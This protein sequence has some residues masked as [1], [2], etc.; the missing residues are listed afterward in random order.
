MVGCL[1]AGAPTVPTPCS[2]R[3]ASVIRFKPPT[4]S[5]GQTVDRTPRDQAGPTSVIPIFIEMQTDNGQSY[6]L[7]RDVIVESSVKP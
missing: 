1:T 3:R 4:F 5:A 7:R 2:Q 6:R